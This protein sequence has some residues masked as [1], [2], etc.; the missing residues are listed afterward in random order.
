MLK[1]AGMNSV[2]RRRIQVKNNNGIC[3]HSI[4]SLEVQGF[5]VNIFSLT[6]T[7]K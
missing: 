3:T 7:Y 1:T 2:R 5:C 6:E 4:L